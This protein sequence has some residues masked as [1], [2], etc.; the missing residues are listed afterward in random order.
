MCQADRPS[1]QS[2]KIQD[3]TQRALM[4]CH[5]GRHSLLPAAHSQPDAAL[6]H[7]CD[8]CSRAEGRGRLRLTLGA[9]AA[10]GLLELAAQKALRCTLAL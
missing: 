4:T 5:V 9:L 6:R 2:K 3:N 1:A 10:A 7:D 8:T